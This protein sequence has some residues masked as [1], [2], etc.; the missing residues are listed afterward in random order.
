MRSSRSIQVNIVVMRTFNAGLSR[1]LAAMEKSCDIKF[2]V[3]F[4]AIHQQMTPADQKKKRPIGF[5]PWNKKL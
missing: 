4:E 2:K 3:L 1:K 5:A